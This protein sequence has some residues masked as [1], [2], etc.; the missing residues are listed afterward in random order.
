M[1]P[2]ECFPPPGPIEV[3]VE[4]AWVVEMIVDEKKKNQCH[5]FLVHWKEHLKHD[6]T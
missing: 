5:Q 2:S 1:Y 6:A 4:E 3:E